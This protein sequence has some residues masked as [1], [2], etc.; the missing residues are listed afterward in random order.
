MYNSCLHYKEREMRSFPGLKI[1]H[2]IENLF[3]TRVKKT[4]Q[5]HL[6]VIIGNVTSSGICIPTCIFFQAYDH[7]LGG[8]DQHKS[9]IIHLFIHF[10]YMFQL[11]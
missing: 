6:N 9:T 2:G 8:K 11:A 4:K 5:I 10:I 3:R 7:G 1:D